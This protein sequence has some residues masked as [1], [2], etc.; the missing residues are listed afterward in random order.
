MLLYTVY[1]IKTKT[2]LWAFSFETRKSTRLLGTEFSEQDAS[3]SPDGRWITYAS[4][5]SGRME[6]Y[7]RPFT[8]GSAAAAPT[9]SA[10]VLVSK[11]GGNWPKWRSDGKELTYLSSDRNI[12]A[13]EVTD[14]GL[15]SFGE[16]TFLL[17][18]MGVGS[19]GD[20]TRDGTRALVAAP[21]TP[22]APP[23]R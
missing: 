14:R 23:Q 13:V 21:V 19:I 7:A 5:E 20:A 16:P 8:P 17:K 11:G 12:M 1:E 4:D 3:I 10:K 6:V 22:N 18:T 2:D 9:T 15:S